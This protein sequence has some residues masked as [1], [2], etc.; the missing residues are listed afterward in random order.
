MFLLYECIRG[1]LYWLCA[2]RNV[3]EILRQEEELKHSPAI[4]LEDMAQNNPT[5]LLKQS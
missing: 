1:R 2:E 5:E 3:F 4:K